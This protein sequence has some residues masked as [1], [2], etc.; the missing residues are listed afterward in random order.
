MAFEATIEPGD[1]L[2]SVLGHAGIPA[3]IRAEAA[4]A[5]SGVYDLTDLRPG[6]RIEWAAASGDSASLTRLSLFVEDGVEIALRF[7]GP[8]AAKRIDPPVRETDR[9]ETLTLDG[10]L[11]D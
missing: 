10:T 2:D 7:D 3:T 5:L 6:H 4:L 11:Y 8:V 1:T 9:R